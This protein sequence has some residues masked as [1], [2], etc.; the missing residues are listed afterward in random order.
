MNAENVAKKA[1]RIFKTA[2]KN[3]PELEYKVEADFDC[4]WCWTYKK[5]NAKNMIFYSHFQNTQINIRL[6][7]LEKWAN[8]SPTH[9]NFPELN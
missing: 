6:E 1:E 2:Q 5:H 8:N 7:L 3:N 9:K 4:V